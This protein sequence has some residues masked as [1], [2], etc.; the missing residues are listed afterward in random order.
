MTPT[1]LVMPFYENPSMLQEHFKILS[2]L[3]G[4]LRD[5][6]SVVVVDDGSPKEP[7][8]PPEDGMLQGMSIQIYRI[9]KDVRW[10]QDAARNLGVVHAETNWVL[11]TDID[12]VVPEAT[13]RTVVMRDHDPECVFR[14][15]RVSAPDMEPYKPHPN[16]WL[17]TK[18]KYD[19]IGGYDERFAGF[20][21]TDGDFRN[22]VNEFAK[23]IVSFKEH[24][25][26]VPRWHIKDASTRTYLR[27]QPEDRVGLAKAHADREALLPEEQRPLRY[28]FD[29][30]RVYP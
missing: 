24:L 22:R 30:V 7:A 17:M 13:W 8:A 9:L 14:F 23:S 29:F 5:L 20:Y 21:G 4:Q 12:H 28:T 6:I 27:K 25:I 18:K 2:Q 1:T 26:R 10:N 11:L 3:P 16:S 19:E 15:A